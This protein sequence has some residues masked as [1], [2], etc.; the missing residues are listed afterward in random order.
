M[1]AL[2]FRDRI[3]THVNN[4]YVS[5][6][7]FYK[8]T[9]LP[10][11]HIENIDQRVTTDIERFC[12]DVANLY[13]SIFKPVLDI[14]LNTI[15]LSAIMGT[16]GPLMLV[17][18]YLILGQIKMK[19]M[20]NFKKLTEVQSELEGNYRTCHSRLIANSEE[21]SF[22][23]G[24]NRERGIITDIFTKLFNHCVCFIFII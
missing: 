18:Y 9:N 10:Q 5:H 6:T 24:A 16:R 2:C 3:T 7:N 13:S 4:M 1:L 14:T 12:E 15:R 21:I 22:Y 20:P 11:S 17:V 19:L 23:D 8:A